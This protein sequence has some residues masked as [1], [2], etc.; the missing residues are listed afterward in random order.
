[1]RCRQES[2]VVISL[3]IDRGL[4]SL[5]VSPPHR[6]RCNEHP[7]CVLP[8]NASGQT[9][10]PATA[11]L[12]LART[13]SVSDKGSAVKLKLIRAD[14][15]CLRRNSAIVAAQFSLATWSVILR[16]RQGI[17]KP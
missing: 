11:I 8:N 13:N 7:C 17:R 15:C 16:G 14:R 4:P 12:W 5:D 9:S 2:V 3:M 1:M 6:Q 10:L